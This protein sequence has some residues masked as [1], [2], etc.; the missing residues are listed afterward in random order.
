MACMDS[1]KDLESYNITNMIYV[2][3]HVQ[4]KE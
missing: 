1:D 3:R 4:K 2:C